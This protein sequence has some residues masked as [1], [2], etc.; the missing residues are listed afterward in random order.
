MTG[1]AERVLA[2]NIELVGTVRHFVEREPHRVGMRAVVE[3]SAE[4]A[5]APRIVDPKTPSLYVTEAHFKGLPY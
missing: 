4:E 5:G 2:A 1:A 3:I